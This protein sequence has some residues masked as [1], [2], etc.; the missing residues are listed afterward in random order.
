MLIDKIWTPFLGNEATAYGNLH[1]DCA[2]ASLEKFIR[3]HF[4]DNQSTQLIFREYGLLKSPDLP[5]MAVSPDGVLF[6]KNDMTK[7]IQ[8]WVLE[9]KCP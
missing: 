3:N 8:W 5:W 1:E 6:L 4:P 7:K 9:Y 2:A